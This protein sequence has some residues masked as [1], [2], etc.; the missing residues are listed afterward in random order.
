MLSVSSQVRAATL[1][2]V[3]PEGETFSSRFS[4]TDPVRTSGSLSS[5]IPTEGND[6]ERPVGGERFSRAARVL[7]VTSRLVA[8]AGVAGLAAGLVSWLI[9]EGVATAFQPPM[10]T[11]HMMGQVIRKA[12]FEDQ[13]AADFKN[14]AVAFGVLGGVMGVVLGLAG[15]TARRSTPAG[16][17]GATIGL[18]VGTLLGAVTSFMILPFYFHALDV[19]KEAL[20]RDLVLPALVHSGIWAAC[21]LAGGLAFGVG[22]DAGRARI[23]NAA[24]GGLIGGALGAVVYEMIGATGIVEGETTSP[25]P[26]NWK[27]RLLARV[28]VATLSALFAAVIINMKGHR[29]S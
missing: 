28:L 9:G 10:Q 16:V 20:S 25:L 21:G 29:N 6:P 1:T 23:F 22:L 18:L 17:R 5:T 13:S 19:A 4:M 14:A 7:P 2:F 26:I 27:A 12:T 3:F 8:V 24:L 15:G 11:Q